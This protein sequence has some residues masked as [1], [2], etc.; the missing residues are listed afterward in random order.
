M[1]AE[2]R[3]LSL[4]ARKPTL[5]RRGS[6]SVFLYSTQ[7]HN[8]FRCSSYPEYTFLRVRAKISIMW[9]A[10]LLVVGL[11]LILVLGGALIRASRRVKRAA[12][13]SPERYWGVQFLL[14][15]SGQ[16]CKAMQALRGQSFPKGQVPLL[17][18]DGCDRRLQCQC[19]Y[20]YL[21][22]RRSG[23]ERRS[24]GERREAIRIDKPDR[25]SGTE[26][27]PWYDLW[28]NRR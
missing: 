16:C 7:P 17:P 10:L 26:R 3:T 24:G 11:A 20:H 13:S 5:E 1:K 19:R 21:P 14:P 6:E 15:T 8:L 2:A 23:Q 25:R 18:L 28:R 9:T 4:V 27:R 22:E 12:P